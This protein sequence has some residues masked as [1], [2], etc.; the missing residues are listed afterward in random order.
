V[1]GLRAARDRFAQLGVPEA[2]AVTADVDALRPARAAG[3]ANPGPSAD[4]GTLT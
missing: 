1:T 2:A 4:P 3:P